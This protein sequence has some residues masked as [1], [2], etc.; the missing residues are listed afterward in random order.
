MM[1][2]MIIF[3]QNITDNYKQYASFHIQFVSLVHQ[4]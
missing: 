2:G 1:K 3:Y 4:E